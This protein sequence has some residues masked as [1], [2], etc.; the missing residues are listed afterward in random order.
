MKL[1]ITVA[2]RHGLMEEH[3]TAI[4]M[5]GSEGRAVGSSSVLVMTGIA[6][7]CLPGCEQTNNRAE[8]LAAIAAMRVQDGSLEIRSDSEYV[9]RVAAG[10]ERQLNNG[11]ET[12]DHATSRLRLGYKACDKSS[13]QQESH[14]TLDKG[15]NDVAD[16]LA[17]A[18]AAH[19]A[20]PQALTE[21]ATQRQLVALS[22]HMFVAEQLFNDEIFCFQWARSITGSA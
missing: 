5:R 1:T 7:S 4:R 18:A 22:T 16:S 3:A 12:E 11:A 21:A 14:S 2:L 19:H 13:H 9:V 20:A 10:P 6:L 15:R 8:L 17:S